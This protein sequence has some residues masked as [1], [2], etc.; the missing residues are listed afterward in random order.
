MLQEFRRQIS[1]I[2]LLLMFRSHSALSIERNERSLG[3]ILQLIDSTGISTKT[4]PEIIEFFSLD[5][6]VSF[7]L[8]P[9]YNRNAVCGCENYLS[10]IRGKTARPPQCI[11]YG[12]FYRFYGFVLSKV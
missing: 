2:I 4:R 12:C 1:L 9:Q 6:L 11:L 3:R 8:Q 5:S 10:R 7:L